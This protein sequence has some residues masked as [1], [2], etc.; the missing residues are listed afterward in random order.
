MTAPAER[1]LAL[2][3]WGAG[4]PRLFR[5]GSLGVG[6]DSTAF[7][8]DPLRPPHTRLCLAANS[9]AQLTTKKFRPV[10]EILTIAD[11]ILRTNRYLGLRQGRLMRRRN[12][13]RYESHRPVSAQLYGLFGARKQGG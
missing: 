2:T 11:A 7:L 1:M 12:G 13:V 9:A 5:E 8:R 10:G 4:G 6:A 3:T